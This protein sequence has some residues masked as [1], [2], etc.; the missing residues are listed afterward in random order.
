MFGAMAA[1]IFGATV[2]MACRIIWCQSKTHGLELATAIVRNGNNT[3]DSYIR[4]SYT[5]NYVAAGRVRR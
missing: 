3:V 4:A 2:V 5:R 1:G